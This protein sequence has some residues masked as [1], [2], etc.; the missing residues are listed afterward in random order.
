MIPAQSLS[1]PTIFGLYVHREPQAYELYSPLVDV[2][3]GGVAIGNA[4]RGLFRTLWTLTTPDGHAVVVT[5]EGGI[6]DTLFTRAGTITELSLA[7]DQGMRPNVAFV[8]DGQAWLWWYDTTVATQVFTEL[9]ADVVNP[10]ITL[11]DKR[12]T[13][14]EAN[15]V[16]LAY[17][18][19]TSLYFRAQ[20][21]RYTVEY[22]LSSG[23]I[24][25]PLR[26]IAMNNKLRLQF[27]FGPLE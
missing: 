12:S 8:E 6:A 9:A 5:P 22:L 3:P 14:A 19:G 23:D 26:K 11:D 4:T 10:R 17:I 15:D 16:I 2:E 25:S 7:F 21:D 1:D 13:Q 18:R 20:R 24:T 27:E